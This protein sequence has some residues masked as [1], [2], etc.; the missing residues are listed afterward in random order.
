VLPI[1]H[2]DRVIGVLAVDSLERGAF[3]FETQDMLTRFT[4]FFYPD[5]RKDTALL[6]LEQQ[7]KTF[8]GRSTR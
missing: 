2:Q 1:L 6:E 8:C 3:S 4:P 7:G 5:H